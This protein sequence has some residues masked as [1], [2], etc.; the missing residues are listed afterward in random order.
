MLKNYTRILSLALALLLLIP[1][2]VAC[3]SSPIRSTDEELRVVGKVGEYEVYYEEL[4]FL[5][6]SYREGL[7]KKYGEYASLDS[8]AASA[9]ESELRE[10]VCSN[11]VSN[12]AI[13]TLA[14]TE[15][16]TLESEGLDERVQK[17]ID[18]MIETSFGGSRS[19]YKKNLKQYGLTD[20]YVRFTAAVDML[21]FDFLAAKLDSGEITDNDAELREI[22]KREFVRTWH[23]MIANNEGDDIE[24][25]RALA[26]EALAKYRDG[27]MSMYKLI[28]SKYNE[29]FTLTTLDGFYF[30]KGS[31]DPV[32][33]AA[34]Y[35][36]EVGEVSEV[37]EAQGLDTSGNTV[38]AFY[39]IQR[40][41]LEDE[42]IN[43]NF[44]ELEEAYR[45]SAVY[46]LLEDVR[47]GLSF[48]PSDEIRSLTLAELQAPKGY[49]PV[50]VIIASVAGGVFLVGG[51]VL[52]VIFLV[53]RKRSKAGK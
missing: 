15:G 35:A 14:A 23:I 11:I 51:A 40:L 22:I 1:S 25:N 8:A 30:T 9:Y 33:E 12:Y 44:Y 47:A 39:V 24:A 17:Y 2:L 27:S 20:R 31:M 18:T 37:V 52:L 21:Y 45:A 7:E 46:E 16:L 43:A 28:G 4:Y 6:N 26:E 41:E 19:E 42:Y 10:L 32:Y 49:S 36:L 3:S 13:L 50:G 5:A 29:D 53:R 34:A 48:E 38:S